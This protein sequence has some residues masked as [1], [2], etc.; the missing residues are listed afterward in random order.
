METNQNMMATAGGRKKNSLTPRELINYHIENPEEP[1][2]DDDILN[3]KLDHQIDAR[4]DALDF[5]LKD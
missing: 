4:L 3:L 5:R 1:I 2:T